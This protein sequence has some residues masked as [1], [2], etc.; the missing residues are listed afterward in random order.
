MR[1]SR[2][3]I[4][5]SVPIAS[6][7]VLKNNV[8]RLPA[9]GWN[10]WN[11][12]ACNIEESKFLTAAQK[13]IDLGLKDVGYEYVNIDDCWQ[14]KDRRDSNGRLIPDPKKFPDGI[15]GTAKKIHDMGLKIGIYSSAGTLTCALYQASLGKEAIDA[16]T[17]AEWGIDYLKY[18]NCQFPSNWN[19]KCDFCVWDD[20][21]TSG[22]R[23]GTCTT[24][25]NLCAAG[26]DYGASNTAKRFSAMRD[27]LLAQSRPILYSLCEWGLAGVQQ[28]GNATG[29]SWRATGDISAKWTRVLSI[30]NQNSFY[31]NN[32]DFWGHS[33][34]DMLEV[35]NNL[36]VAEGR[37]HFALWAAMK[38][39]L[40][41]GTDLAKIK[42]DDL[43]TLKN[44]NLLAFNQDPV[45]GK[46]AM[47]YKWGTNPNW[48]FNSSFPA[49]F[50]SGAYSN[51]STLVLM[52]N[53]YT[54]TK[55]KTAVWGEIPQLKGGSRYQVTDVWTGQSL[56]CVQD[57]LDMQV[58]A[59]D[60]A[61][62]W[63]SGPCTGKSFS[64]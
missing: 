15:S 59:H 52:F 40:L 50:W 42:T 47:P 56:G 3:F 63:I 33:D 58:G 51:G 21:R 38:S 41:I 25:K 29:S 64:G 17:W 23:N 44:T 2:Y 53:P 39:P 12:F 19:D 48:T 18:D 7:L 31:L 45:Y 20:D 46:P 22:L 43:K 10:S 55:T 8:G 32:V 16:Q 57:K 4:L 13:F 1:A 28:W 24:S 5:G 54:A 11:A 35:G 27:A 37:S 61:G 30:L 14:V 49:E 62:L 34:A 36:N 60:T 6:A 9:L 26:Y